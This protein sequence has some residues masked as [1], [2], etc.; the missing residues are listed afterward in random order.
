MFSQEELDTLYHNYQST[1]KSYYQYSDKLILGLI[2]YQGLEQMDLL[3]LNLSDLQ[4]DQGTI[5]IRAG[6]SQKQSRTLPLENHQIMQLHNYIT[7]HRES[8]NDK[9]LSRQCTKLDRL[10]NQLKRLYEQVQTQ[11]EVLEMKIKKLSQL[12]QSRIAHWIKTEKGY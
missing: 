5:Y 10:H 2:I 9:L 8:E 6:R 1:N 4:L 7:K 3:H 12:R 11:G